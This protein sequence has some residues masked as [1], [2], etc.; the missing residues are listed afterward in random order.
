MQTKT[1][2]QDIISETVRSW[3][4]SGKYRNGDHL[5][6]NKDLAKIFQVNTRTV[7]AGLNKLVEENLIEAVPRRGTIVKGVSSLPVSNTVPLLTLSKGDFYGELAG[8]TDAEL[9]KDGLFPI[10]AD[11][12]IINHPGA[13]QSFM[14]RLLA[15]QRHYGFLIEGSTFVPFE[16]IASRPDIFNN[17]VF[18]FTYHQEKE[19]PHCRYVLTDYREMGRMAAD[20]FADHGKKHII[21]PAKFEADYTGPWSSIQVMIMEGIKERAEER[22]IF[23]DEEFFWKRHK[24]LDLENDLMKELFLADNK[25]DALFCWNDGF[26]AISILPTL[27]EIGEENILKMGAL[28]TPHAEKLGFASFDLH[29][30]ET[31]VAAISMLTGRETRRK[32]LIKPTIVEHKNEL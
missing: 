32:I 27:K 3:I 12:K 7:L 24:T 13:F 1:F 6:N 22:G 10:F 5:P 18:I 14:D 23:F 9:A 29:S 2:K 8:Y 25:P 17:T 28:N 21:F 31:A 4:L 16:H 20:Y 19:I 30:Q 11:G 15:R 26:M